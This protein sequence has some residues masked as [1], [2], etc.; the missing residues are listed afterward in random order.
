MMCDDDAR[1]AE[2]AADEEKAELEQSFS[3]DYGTDSDD[4]DDNS[5]SDEEDEKHSA[6]AAESS[7]QTYDGAAYTNTDHGF[8]TRVI[9]NMEQSSIKRRK[10]TKKGKAGRTFK[11]DFKY[12][13]EHM[14]TRLETQQR[15]CAVSYLP[16]TLRRLSDWQLSPDRHD[17]DERG[18][19]PGQRT[20]GLP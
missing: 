18:L 2:C 8:L 14:T 7:G 19:H 17:N 16:L 12:E 13:M 5:D 9:R 3:A 15:L 6:G 11:S 10:P 1:F 4:D 20:I